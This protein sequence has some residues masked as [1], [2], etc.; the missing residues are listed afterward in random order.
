M[1][2]NLWSIRVH[3]QD[4]EPHTL[5]TVASAT[6]QE[7]RADFEDRARDVPEWSVALA[8]AGGTY[9][10]QRQIRELD[11]DTMPDDEVPG[12]YR[13]AYER[14][15]PGTV[16]PEGTPLG[17]AD[18]MLGA[19]KRFVVALDRHADRLDALRDANGDIPERNLRAF[20]EAAAEYPWHDAEAVAHALLLYLVAAGA[21]TA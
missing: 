21:L 16:L 6:E 18:A 19:L 12:L 3:D 7:A 9:E 10:A 5:T 13:Q 20:E 2:T 15:Y 11:A 8:D 14:L 17:T 1:I 4:G